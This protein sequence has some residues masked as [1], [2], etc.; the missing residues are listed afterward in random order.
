MSENNPF[1]N[2]KFIKDIKSSFV[3]QQIFKN[4]KYNN[5]IIDI[6]FKYKK[7]NI[8]FINIK[9]DDGSKFE[10]AYILKLNSKNCNDMIIDQ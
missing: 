6:S 2:N 3:P 1:L 5:N 9:L 8:V 7:N 4:N 10:H